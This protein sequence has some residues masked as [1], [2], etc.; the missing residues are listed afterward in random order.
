MLKISWNSTGEINNKDPKFISE[1]EKLTLQNKKPTR[2]SFKKLLPTSETLFLNV[3]NE[4]SLMKSFVYSKH[5]HI[6]ILII[7]THLSLIV[8]LILTWI[9]KRFICLNLLKF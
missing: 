3:L 6:I 5:G 1:T 9:R 8:F 4:I 7:F 2:N